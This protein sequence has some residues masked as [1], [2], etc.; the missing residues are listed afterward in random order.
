MRDLTITTSTTGIDLLCHDGGVS[1]PTTS[2]QRRRRGSSRSTTSSAASITGRSTGSA[3]AHVLYTDNIP[4]DSLTPHRPTSAASSYDYHEEEPLTSLSRPGSRASSYKDL[5]EASPS[6][7]VTSESNTLKKVTL[8]KQRSSNTQHV[9][10]LGS[11]LG[12]QRGS[13]RRPCKSVEDIFGSPPTEEVS[14]TRNTLIQCAEFLD[15]EDSE[16]KRLAAIELY[17]KKKEEE[18]AESRKVKKG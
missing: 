11:S 14:R 7:S 10:S 18:E 8:K 15:P 17:R 1:L 5:I 6:L 13:Q 2:Y 12:S 4:V 16:E 9:S 3:A